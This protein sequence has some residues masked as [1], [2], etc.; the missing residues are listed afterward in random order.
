MTPI[1]FLIVLFALFAISRA[2]RQFRRGALTIG[3]LMVWGLFWVAVSGVVLSPQTTDLI[4][5]YAGVGR[6]ADFIIY[7][8]LTGLFYLVF[9][10]FVKIEGVEREVTAL[11]R[12][13]ALE[14][15]DKPPRV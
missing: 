8:S 5:Q 13:I 4:A 3:R 11:V 10:L 6:G 12:K 15:E 1:Q 9:R 2:L 14:D 7:L